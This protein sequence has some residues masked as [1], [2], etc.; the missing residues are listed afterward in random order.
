MKNA[1]MILGLLWAF[2]ASGQIYID[3]YR[4]GGAPAAGLLLDDYPAQAA[5][6][7]RKLRTAYTGNCL[8]VQKTGTSDTLAIGWHG[9]YMDTTAIVAFCA[10]TTCDV[11]RWYDQSGNS[12][13]L[14]QNTGTSQPRIFQSNAIVVRSATDIPRK[15]L[16]GV[17][18]FMNVA[19]TRNQPHA[20]A[21]VGTI[22]PTAQIIDGFSQ[23]NSASVANVNS[24]VR[25]GGMTVTTFTG[26]FV[27]SNPTTYSLITALWNGANSQAQVN[28]VSNTGSVG[29]NTA[30]GLT[31]MSAAG[32]VV[33]NSGFIQEAIIWTSN[34][35]SDWANIR[36][37]IN[38][39]YS[40][41]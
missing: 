40:V 13:D 11:R 35:T 15:A 20:A 38:A 3:S 36:S 27:N 2:G 21:V 12:R 31:I 39:F 9:N 23:S 22:S 41:Y 17:G 14:V 37:N 34:N 29:T 25:I 26:F 32:G 6:S 7:L 5:Y 33:P 16:L 30:A 10:G 8:V 1:L 24:Q 19:F 18:S 4:F 28:N